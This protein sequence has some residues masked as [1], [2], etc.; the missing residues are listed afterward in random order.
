MAKKLKFPHTYVIIFYTIIIAA[1][2][3]WVIPGGEYVEEISIVNGQ[4]STQMV[5]KPVESQP[6]TWEVFAA[7]FEG[8][9]KQAGIIVFIFMIGGAFWIMNESKSI[10]VGIF[11]FLDVTRKLEKNRLIRR[12]G[13][14]NIV[15]T[16]IMLMF[17][18]F[19]AVFGM[20]E[21]TIAFIIILVPLAI[22]MGY[23]SITGV[24]LV[25]VSA[26]LGF[27][28]A[29]LNPFTIGIAQ[30]IAELPLFSGLEYRLFCW[31]VINVI[32]IVYILRWA[33]KVKKNPGAS[34]VYEDDEYWRKGHAEGSQKVKY[35]TPLA[36]WAIY[37]L[38]L[39]ALA[40]FAFIYPTTPM[41]VGDYPP[42]LLPMVPIG[43]GLFAVGG[44]FS[45]RKSVH[46]FILNLLTF[47]I[48]FLIVG[49]MG[50]S[51]YI[52]E[53]ATLF[54]AM[55]ILSGIAMDY[56]PNRI[57]KLFIEGMKDIL[58]AAVIVGLAGGIIVILED[59]KIISTILHSMSKGMQNA[60]EVTSI[61]IMYIIQN[62]IN[63]LIPSGS[64]KAAITMPIMAPFSDLIGLSRQAT[65]MAFQFGDGFTN[66]ITPTSGVLMGVLGVA[67]I[68]Y[69]KWVRWVWPLILIMLI[70]GFLLLIPTVTMDLP[71]FE[72]NLHLRN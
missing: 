3:S 29:I 71:G 1:I 12:L 14:D 70:L 54:F 17:S 25:F 30:G 37:A 47:T 7:L 27:A 20:S 56:S 44:L 55:G 43:V 38:T 45:L 68:P 8:F 49:V 41:K 62:I 39:V 9:E 40:I 72:L 46:F 60:G 16:L 57:T 66:M 6:Q 35:H 34:Y 64:A 53:I 19:G 21:E 32:G 59:G 36:A 18:V 48:Y 42:L 58:S 2:L 69:N 31:V 4:E 13:V 51:W 67:K 5:F 50:Y 26:G 61:G 11:S 52:M 24:G 15:M 63:I 23:D 65:V 22:S 10:D 28:G 33:K